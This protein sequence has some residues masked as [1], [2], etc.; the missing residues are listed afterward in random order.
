M[1]VTTMVTGNCGT[2][3][4]QL[5][6]ILDS[7]ERKGAHVNILT[8]VGHNTIREQVMGQDSGAPSSQQLQAMKAQ[9]NDAM[10]A[11]AVGLSTGLQYA[12]GIFSGKGE[13]VALAE[14]AAQYGGIY[15]THVRDEGNGLIH[16]LEE[17]VDICKRARIP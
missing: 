15:V 12:P 10:R 14:V 17:A 5:R 2:S 9:V 6:D 16:W 1:G 7:L 11:G 13:L 3:H 4:K 8:L